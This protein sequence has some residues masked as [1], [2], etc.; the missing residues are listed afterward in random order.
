MRIAFFSDV[1]LPSVNGVVTSLVNLSKEL[2]KK[3]HAVLIFYPQFPRDKRVV[4]K[5]AGLTLRPVPSVPSFFYPDFRVALLN[6]QTLLAL[7]RFRPDVI[8]LETVG[9][10]GVEG[11]LG[12]RV[13][14]KP[15]VGTFHGYFMEPEY[16]KL[17]KL[18]K[19]NGVS[20]ALWRYSA[21][22]YNQCHRV[23]GLSNYIAD[24]L[25]KHGVTSEITILP[26]GLDLSFV[27]RVDR[28]H[29]TM[30]QKRYAL[31]KRLVISV[32][33]LSKEKSLE[34]LVRA[35]CTVAEQ[36]DGVQLL[37]VGEGPMRG[38]LQDLVIRLK[39]FGRVVFTGGIDHDELLTSGLLQAARLF[40]MA[41]TSE[42]QPMSVLE[43]MAVGLPIVGVRARGMG[44]LV[45]DNGVLV[46]PGDVE[47]LARAMVGLLTSASFWRRAAAA[48]RRR[49]ELFDIQKVTRQME[50]LYAQVSERK[51]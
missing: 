27:G 41:S 8:H 43:A 7:R 26:N 3:G 25:R 31:G 28:V 48:S 51:L 18:D 11:I 10:L 16:L 24:D 2:G 30:L 29:L 35:F 47:G 38:E 22:F 19:F 1:F 45:E 37:V 6:P 36:V 46:E 9:P 44:D 40:A 14:K 42:A 13:L 32:G 21:K 34:L 15:I 20:R 4:W 49:S 50:E 12:A 33:R 5:Q 23:V 17:V 39:L